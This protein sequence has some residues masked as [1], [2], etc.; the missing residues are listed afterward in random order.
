MTESSS[1]GDRSRMASSVERAMKISQTSPRFRLPNGSLHPFTKPVDKPIALLVRMKGDIIGGETT[2]I[3]QQKADSS[4]ESLSDFIEYVYASLDEAGCVV[5][6]M[7]VI[8][9]ISE[10]EFE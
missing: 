5:I 7:N 2:T 3:V 1:S 9:P 10:K 4:L 6:H 8:D